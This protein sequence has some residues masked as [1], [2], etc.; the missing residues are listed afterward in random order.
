MLNDL[1]FGA[2]FNK[3]IHRFYRGNH[4]LL[5]GWEDDKKTT[6][7]AI[8]E[9]YDSTDATAVTP[10]LTRRNGDAVVSNET[11]PQSNEIVK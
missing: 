6:A 5:T 7:N 3:S 4:W 8:G 9:G 11:I 1:P 2:L 10:T